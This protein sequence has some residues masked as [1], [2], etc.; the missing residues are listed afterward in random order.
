MFVIR[1]KSDGKY[2]RNDK[3]G[4]WRCKGDGFVEDLQDVKPFRTKGAAKASCNV[5]RH[6]TDWQR[7]GWLHKETRAECCKAVKWRQRGGW[8]NQCAHYKA[9]VK[10]DEDR[11]NELYELVVVELRIK[12]N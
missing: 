2:W 7:A 6:V 12:E 8:T 1:R 5:T 9:A 4:G 3:Q 11:W 10:A